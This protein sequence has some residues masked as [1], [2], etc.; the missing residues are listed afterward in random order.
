MLQRHRKDYM[1]RYEERKEHPGLQQ[2]RDLEY[3]EWLEKEDHK[4]QAKR[5]VNFAQLAAPVVQRQAIQGVAQREE[6]DELSEILQQ[7]DEAY[8]EY[9]LESARSGPAGVLARPTTAR[10][11]EKLSAQDFTVFEEGVQAVDATREI[12]N[13]IVSA[14]FDTF[15]LLRTISSL[16]EAFLPSLDGPTGEDYR[17]VQEDIRQRKAEA[18]APLIAF[19]SDKPAAFQAGFLVT[20]KNYR[21]VGELIQFVAEALAGPIIFRGIGFGIRVGGAVFRRSAQAARARQVALRLQEFYVVRRLDQIRLVDRHMAGLLMREHPNLT[22]V[23]AERALNGPPGTRARLV[24][25]GELVTPD[26]EFLD[27]TQNV[28]LRREVKAISG[29]IDAFKRQLKKG[30]L[31]VNYSGDVI[32]QVPKGV[33]IEQWMRSFVGSRTSVDADMGRYAG[34]TIQIWDESGRLLLHGR[35]MD[36]VR[37]MQ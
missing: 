23:T 6:T 37:Y 10:L 20:M 22:R 3:I 28:L 26:I 21:A 16:S 12:W 1:P 2:T 33:D 19:L 13:G 31:Q 14:F 35:L 8:Q 30:A 4:D 7:Y 11:R 17:E 32:L 15:D 18:A 34:V 27:R 29:G 5:G 9:V 24:Q 25:T 36:W